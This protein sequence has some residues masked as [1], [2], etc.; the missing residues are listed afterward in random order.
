MIVIAIGT[1]RKLFSENPTRDRILNVVSGVEKYHA[2]VFTLAKDKF[3]SQAIGNAVFHPTNSKFKIFYIFDAIKIGISLLKDF[4]KSEKDKIVVSTQD[5]FECG[6]VGLVLS[7]KFNIALHVQIHTDLFSPF[8]KNTFLQ[9]IRMIIAPFV[10]RSAKSIRCDSKRMK[11][12]ILKRKWSTAPIE[13]LPIFIDTEKY[14]KPAVL[15]A[16]DLFSEKRFVILMASRLEAEKE[17]PMAID[18]FS[19]IN[20]KYPKRV[21]LII[22]GSGSMEKVLKERVKS[23]K[24]EHSVAFVP[25]TDDLVSYY[26]TSD[27]FWMNSLFEGYGLTIAEALLSGTPVL[28]SD[29]GV[30][31]EIVI[32]GKNGWICEPKDEICF[33]KK[34]DIILSEAKL[35]TEVKEYMKNNP[36]K[37]SYADRF[38]YDK[39]LIRNMEKAIESKK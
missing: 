21:G 20:H 10:I 33:Y 31:P 37:H 8:F 39:V 16:H 9:Y 23:L 35:Q 25:W 7:K 12:G 1:E 4:N 34:I 15:D 13:V 5:P 18:V 19:K 17:I 2:I 29:V 3:K 6:F 24:I 30:A 26:K 28:T 27:L 22:V 14:N 32:E 38:E 36:Y 11:D